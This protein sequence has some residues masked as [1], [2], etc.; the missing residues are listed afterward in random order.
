M[1]M[2]KKKPSANKSSTKQ[3]VA[4]SSPGTETSPE[5]TSKIE[6]DAQAE[7][8]FK[9]NSETKAKSDAEAKAKADAEAKAKSDAEEKAK[10]DEKAK[11]KAS[12]LTKSISVRSKSKQGFRRA[13][14]A[15]GPEPKIIPL[16]N[17]DDAKLK[18]LNNEPNLIVEDVE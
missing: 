14:F 9:E 18:A 17:L 2:T 7:T 16:N 6:L 1:T 11:A 12:V 4:D 8:G 3:S 15:F 5:T 13:G 10:A